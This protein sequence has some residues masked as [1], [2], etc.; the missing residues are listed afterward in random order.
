MYATWVP[1]RVA[2]QMIGQKKLAELTNEKGQQEAVGVGD[3]TTQIFPTPFYFV[4]DL[5]VYADAVLVTSG[6]VLSIASDGQVFA[7]FATAPGT[8][9]V[10]TASSTDAVNGRNLDA[11]FL[12]AQAEVR[13]PIDAAL[14]EV[15]ADDATN[16]PPLILGWAE[17]IAWYLLISGPR[18]SR[19]LEAYPEYEKRYI[20]VSEGPDSHLKR[21]ANETFSLRGV[22]PYRGTLAPFSPPV[23]TVSQD[24]EFS[25]RPKVYQGG[26][27]VF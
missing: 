3:T 14:Y 10:I 12:R 13:G 24:V 7:T 22:L 11:A 17:D 21:V 18:R 9:S 25:S 5:N 19:L 6:C 4:A 2:M 1:P 15:P 8:G 23:E 20:V 27:G 16:V 26:R